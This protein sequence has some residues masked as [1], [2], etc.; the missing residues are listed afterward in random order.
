MSVPAERARRLLRLTG[1]A[2]GQLCPSSGIRLSGPR[3]P[4]C[5]RAI[6]SGRTGSRRLRFAHG[7]GPRRRR[8]IT[9]ELGRDRTLGQDG[10]TRLRLLAGQA[11][12]DEIRSEVPI[13][14]GRQQGTPEPALERRRSGRGS[15][16][17]RVHGA[18]HDGFEDS[19]VGLS[20]RP[21]LA[22]TELR[23]AEPVH[24]SNQGI[25]CS[26]LGHGRPVE[27]PHHGA[28]PRQSADFAS[29]G[30]FTLLRE[31]HREGLARADELPWGDIAEGIA[32]V[33]GR[34]GHASRGGHSIT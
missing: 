30:L 33:F 3:R 25:Q 15:I 1:G 28:G 9:E 21:K 13:S 29:L 14:H 7:R 20:G 22:L 23:A 18:P 16:V 17:Q 34:S 26:G 2:G 4:D 24:R 5:P 12:R 6:R 19:P 8:A 27:R 10:E 32:D 31:L 11:P